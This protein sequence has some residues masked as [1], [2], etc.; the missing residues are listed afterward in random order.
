M[1]QEN[2]IY[3]VFLKKFILPFILG[4]GYLFINKLI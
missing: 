2:K 3:Y 4:K 1:H